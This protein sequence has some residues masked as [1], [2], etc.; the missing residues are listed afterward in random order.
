MCYEEYSLNIAKLED[1][2]YLVLEGNK[3]DVLIYLK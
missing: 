3:T 2:Q 1:H